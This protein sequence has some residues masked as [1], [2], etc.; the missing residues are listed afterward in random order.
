MKKLILIFAAVLSLLFTSCE[1][2]NF[3]APE[4]ILSGTV[5]YNGNPVG[6]RTNGTELELWQDGYAL[7]EKITV[8][9]AQDGTY[10]ARLFNGQYK[11]VRHAG[12]P[13]APQLNDT[14]IIDVNGDTSENI[15][16]QPYFTISN[17]SYQ[18]YGNAVQANFEVNQVD[19]TASLTDVK[20]FLRKDIL[21]DE[22]HNDKAVS[23][24]PGS[25]TF[26][27]NASILA[28]LPDELLNAGYLF[29]R[30]GVKS[31]KANEYYY[32]Q[33]QKLDINSDVPTNPEAGFTVAAYG[34]EQTF[35]NTST[36]G[37]SYEWDF[38]DG[39]TST[40][41][42][43][44]H[45]YDTE[46]SYTVKLT[47]TGED[48][49]LPNTYTQTID[50][51]YSQIAVENGDFQQPGTGKIQNWETI[52]GWSSDTLVTDSGIDGPDG[53]GNFWGYLWNQEPS[54]YQL[55]DHVIASGEVFKISLDAWDA[56]F[57]GDNFTVTLYYDAGDGTRNVIATNT[58]ETLG[59]DLEFTA[60]ATEASGGSKLGIEFKANAIGNTG[61]E[62]NG[63]T[64]FDNVELFF[65]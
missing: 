37:V 32:S 30:V 3:Q 21:L 40:E 42:N 20:L 65:K 31:D 24:D 43:P 35:S 18:Q 22:N 9:I 29:L 62:N 39:A 57:G 64:A 61:W 25:I 55:T 33:V 19:P 28:V 53:N 36:N 12:A 50:V 63:W 26:G 11:M 56:Y 1:V 8:H 4:S 58:F 54:V 60:P 44:V 52:P 17:A 15:E 23:I 59:N 51:G 46:G 2:D 7:D 34:R 41:E 5:N 13:W 14:I 10:T 16:V 48:G 38:G 45:T 6:V 47:A 27:D 49:T